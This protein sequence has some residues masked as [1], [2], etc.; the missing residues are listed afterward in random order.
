MTPAELAKL[1]QLAMRGVKSAEALV[2]R[3]KLATSYNLWQKFYTITEKSIKPVGFKYVGIVMELQHSTALTSL[4]LS[5]IEVK[6]VDALVQKE[7]VES[8]KRLVAEAIKL[9]PRPATVPRVTVP[10]LAGHDG[11]T[12]VNRTLL[13][14]LGKSR[15]ILMRKHN[16]TNDT[17]AL[18][19]KGR[20][21]SMLKGAG[22]P[23]VK[24]VIKM[25]EKGTSLIASHQIY[26]KAYKDEN[27]LAQ[28]G[29]FH[30]SADLRS[31]IATGKL[32]RGMRY[33]VHGMKVELYNIVPYGLDM[34]FG[35]GWRGK[36]YAHSPIDSVM[37]SIV[38][39]DTAIAGMRAQPF[40][41]PSYLR[42]LKVLQ[43]RISAIIKNVLNKV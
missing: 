5:P 9:A 37:S 20:G 11:S 42:E 12:S 36:R 41:Y 6:A 34:E 17:S 27:I 29:I 39:Y 33:E 1:K 25:A 18:H 19:W 30:N 10:S 24:N 35:T 13:A 31:Y 40:I 8:G 22:R 26:L 43:G 21:L 23:A 38:K 16:L 2:A 14:H 3:A 28:R 15:M 7:L 32:R 4:G